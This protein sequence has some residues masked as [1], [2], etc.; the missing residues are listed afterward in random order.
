M[1]KFPKCDTEEESEQMLLE[2]D[3]DRLAWHKITINFQFIKNAVKRSTM[4]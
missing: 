4:K 2:N 1:Q 3:T